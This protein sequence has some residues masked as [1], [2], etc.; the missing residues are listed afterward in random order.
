[1]SVTTAP[2]VLVVGAS[3]RGA[4]SFSLALADSVVGALLHEH[5]A[6]Q[7]D[8]LD[9]FDLAPFATES[10]AAKMA[11]LAGE[12][13]PADLT[14]A[15]DGVRALW[16]RVA[17]AD[18]LVLAVPIWNHGV[19]WALK[20]FIDTVT[21]P[22]MAFGFDPSEGYRGL[23]G[24]RRAVAVYTSAVW[25]PGVAPSFGTDEASA[26]VRGWLSFVGIDDVQEVRLHTTYPTPDLAE[27]VA[28][29]HDD[30]RAAGRALAGALV[31]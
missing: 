17:A 9:V 24:G 21:Q 2:R 12:D 16:E 7:V 23:L 6:A 1:M 27:R 20:L 15:W 25:S 10:T 3:P 11:V 26:A 18:V 30:A 19:P 13:V 4:A 22:G 28:R 14:A 29:A 31:R 5:P 8:R